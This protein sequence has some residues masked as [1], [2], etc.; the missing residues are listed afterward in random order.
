[1]GFAAGARDPA[2]RPE[3]LDALQEARRRG[4]FGPRPVADQLAHAK[5]FATLLV[6]AGVGPRA[7]LD[8]GSGG[9]LPG[10]VL[11]ARWTDEQAVLV[12]ASSRRTAF[13]R[14]TVSALGWTERV[15][16]AEGR[17]EVLARTV[18][19][20][21]AFPLVVARSFAAPAVTAE[22]GGAFVAVGGTLAVSEPVDGGPRWSVEHLK[23]LGLGPV[24][25][26]PGA[27]ARVAL[28]ERLTPLEPRWPRGDGV[29]TKRPLW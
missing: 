29:P 7:F 4:F 28:I 25:L 23:E 15:T 18:E 26:R 19:L 5:A 6:E 16:I 2:D 27:D 8:L 13:L 11:A 22:I 10:L 17:A 21:Q 12:D 9:G 1:M 24:T 3:L 20:R 14:D